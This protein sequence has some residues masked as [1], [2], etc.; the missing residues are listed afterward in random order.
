MHAIEQYQME[1][2]LPTGKRRR[3]VKILRLFFLTVNYTIKCNTKRKKMT[4]IETCVIMKLPHN[5][6][7][8][9]SI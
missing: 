2:H 5:K 7:Q 8:E 6:K 1:Q 9:E 3:I 4:H